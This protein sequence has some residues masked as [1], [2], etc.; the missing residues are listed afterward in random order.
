MAS[1]VCV[2]SI[3]TDGDRVLGR[4]R[5]VKALDT[6][7]MRIDPLIPVT[8]LMTCLD[9][10]GTVRPAIIPHGTGQDPGI[11]RHPHIITISQEL[12]RFEEAASRLKDTYSLKSK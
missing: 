6:I 2:W 12:G 7:P 3:A 9:F 11:G 8:S 10:Y 1:G 5:N 4:F